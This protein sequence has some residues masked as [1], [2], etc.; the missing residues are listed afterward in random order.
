MRIQRSSQRV[1]A[2]A[3]G[4]GVVLSSCFGGVFSAA[5]WRSFRYPGY[6]IC[7]V[8]GITCPVAVL[9]ACFTRAPIAASVLGPAH[10]M[11]G[12][13]LCRAARALGS[14]VCATVVDLCGGAC[15]SPGFCGWCGVWRAS[16]RELRSFIFTLP[17]QRVRS[18]G[19]M[20]KPPVGIEPTT[21]RLR[22]ACSAN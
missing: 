21:V 11:A 4:S 15:Q 20:H 14:C 12:G 19:D 8:L 13:V 6:R 7:W 18:F 9:R 16:A 22:S 5:V 1:G 10:P 3:Q 17:L 2:S